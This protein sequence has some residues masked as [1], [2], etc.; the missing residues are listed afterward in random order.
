MRA[1]VTTAA[2]ESGPILLG[3]NRL[4]NFTS[5]LSTQVWAFLGCSELETAGGLLW[6]MPADTAP[7]LSCL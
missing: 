5:G 6:K 4:S 2:C 7:L 1:R 3:S